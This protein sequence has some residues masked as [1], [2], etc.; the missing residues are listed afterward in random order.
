MSRKRWVSH[1][2]SL[3]LIAAVAMTLFACSTPSGQA[4][5][6]PSP[7]TF[8]QTTTGQSATEQLVITN[9]ASSG[10]LTVE[11][12]GI[13]G[14]DAAVFAD[15]FDDDSAVVLD[16]GE[17]MTLPVVFSPT[18]VGPRSATLHVNNS[19]TSAVSVPL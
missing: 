2:G 18:T 1:T 8:P 11:S 9:V 17:S 19:G 6:T 7:L 13:S 15:Q 16:P 4:E 12:T 5:A 3:L 10:S 14:P